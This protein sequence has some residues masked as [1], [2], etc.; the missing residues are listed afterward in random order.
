[1]NIPTGQIR[2]K[3]NYYM[4]RFG[5]HEDDFEI[6]TPEGTQTLSARSLVIAAGA[7]P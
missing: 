7:R 2:F 5:F 3:K 4:R 6:V 1:M